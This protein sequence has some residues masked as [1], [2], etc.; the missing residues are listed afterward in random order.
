MTL[1]VLHRRDIHHFF[2]LLSLFLLS[3]VSVYFLDTPLINKVTNKTKTEERLIKKND[4]PSRVPENRKT[5]SIEKSK[6]KTKQNKTSKSF[7][8]SCCKIPCFLLFV[9]GVFRNKKKKKQRHKV[10]HGYTVIF[11]ELL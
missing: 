8:N 4:L 2:W 1:H 5:K 9:F 6:N 7:I 10:V 3:A 11:R